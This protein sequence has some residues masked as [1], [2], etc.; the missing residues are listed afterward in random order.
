M[1][2]HLS[3]QKNILNERPLGSYYNHGYR[4]S[5][6]SYYYHKKITVLDPLGGPTV[7]INRPVSH[8]YKTIQ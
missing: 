3:T 8:T 2:C 1:V 7:I 4:P 5:W 6:W